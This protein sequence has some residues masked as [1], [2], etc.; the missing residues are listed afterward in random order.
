VATSHK[1]P[2]LPSPLLCLVALGIVHRLHPDWIKVN[3]GDVARPL[4]IALERVSRLVSRAIALFE[5]V[6]A[7]LTRRGRPA[8][9]PDAQD[10]D[11]ELRLSRELL[12]VASSLLGQAQW[13]RKK[14]R[15]QIVGA[16][17]RL[18]SIPSMTQARFCGALGLSERTLRAWLRN[19]PRTHPPP[20]PPEPKPP[21]PAR[22]PRRPRFGFDVTLPDTQI[23]A[24][25]TD[26]CAFGV[27][28]KLIAAQDI[29]G[30]DQDLFDSVL[31]DDHESADKVVAVLSKALQECP[32]AQGITDQGTPYMA[33]L[34]RDALDELQ[35]EH[36]PQREANPIGKATVERAFRTIKDIARPLLSITDRV[37][38]M[39]PTLRVVSFAKAFT[40]L[41]VAALLRAYQHGARAARNA[42]QMRAGISSNELASLAEQSRERARA[43][44]QS[45]RLLLAHIHELYA[46]SGTLR[47]FVDSLRRYPVS[48]LHEAERMLQTQMHRDD[49]RDRR[50]YFCTL[51]RRAYETYRRDRARE[52][53]EHAA[54]VQHTRDQAAHQ[55]RFAAWRQDPASWL[56]DALDLIAMQWIPQARA[57]FADG[58][59]LGLGYLQAALSRLLELHGLAATQQIATGVL[60]R[61]RLTAVD[62]IGPN[63][64]DAVAAILT[65]QLASATTT[66][67]HPLAPTPTSATLSLAGLFSRPPLSDRLRN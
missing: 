9:D 30:R 48:V 56:H 28:L 3:V 6:L 45:A 1:S 49:I 4:G 42:D 59:G 37:A 67:T 66:P 8:C 20:P 22:P 24:D 52:R 31:I 17:Q 61:F 23:G 58:N 55:A 34:T 54:N 36:A 47:S 25:T 10:R 35:A 40:T 29:G 11:V 60:H 16:W 65:R 12:T 64:T 7:T 39:M 18:S 32:G 5:R 38:D 44:D 50:R 43:T 27:P 13:G 62:R 46:L 33:E 51:V 53:L 2:P 14:P 19:A 41:L 15:D 57:L 21:R 63:G 26:L